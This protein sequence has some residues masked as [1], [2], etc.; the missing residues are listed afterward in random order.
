MSGDGGMST[1]IL[2][3]PITRGAS[4]KRWQSG[5]LE[6]GSEEPSQEVA[7]LRAS[8][9]SQSLATTLTLLPNTINGDNKKN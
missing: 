5:T 3:S 6:Q 7:A 2:T 1:A 4:R 9:L 8:Q